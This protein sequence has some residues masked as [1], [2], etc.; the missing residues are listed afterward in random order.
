MR[1]RPESVGTIFFAIVITSGFI[2]SA[3]AKET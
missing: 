1:L 2:E 3:D